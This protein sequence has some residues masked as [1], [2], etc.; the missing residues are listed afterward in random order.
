VLAF[1]VAVTEEVWNL[2]EQIQFYNVIM[3]ALVS[4]VFLSAFIFYIHGGNQNDKSRR[5][6][7][8][9]V[10]ATYGVTLL[11]C[12]AILALVGKFP[13]FSDTAI[14]LKRVVLVA[15]PA[16]VSATVVDS[17]N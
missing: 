15:F 9:R 8:S 7:I 1:P 14:A 5:L 13:V 17:L 11:V 4:C 12:A 3:I 16:S 6:E 10:V 2:S